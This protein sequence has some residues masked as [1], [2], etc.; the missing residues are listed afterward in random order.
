MK[1]FALLYITDNLWTLE[2][3]H[4]SVGA[5]KQ[6]TTATEARAWAK[7]QGLIVR[8]APNCDST[9]CRIA[10]A[11]YPIGR[12][13]TGTMEAPMPSRI[14]GYVSVLLTATGKRGQALWSERRDVTAKQA[15]A[16][17]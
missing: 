7:A 6:F 3:L 1:T 4:P 13:G 16:I 2:P 12:N 17:L 14:P 10:P 11:P 9:E 15:A 8:R 5:G